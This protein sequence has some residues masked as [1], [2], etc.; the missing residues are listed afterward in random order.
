MNV[1]LFGATGTTGSKVLVELLN[2][3][4]LVK[5]V[6]RDVS[7]IQLQHPNLQPMQGNVLDPG[8]V[9]EVIKGAD[10][11]VST[12]SEG[13]SI[14][15][16]TQSKGNGNIIQA[17]QAQGIPR[18][19][20]MGAEGILNAPDGTLIREDPAYPEPY[21]PLSYEHSRVQELLQSSTLQWTQVC[22]P[23]ILPRNADGN[24]TVK[25]NVPA[26]STGKVNAGNIGAFIAREIQENKFLRTRVGIANS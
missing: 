25:P 4:Y 6:A 2:A 17:M 14:V 26:A 3:G 19:I 8:F 7:R 5:A 18:F 15:Q 16:H 1:V 24:Y 10:A 20:C 13:V 23:L 21:K 12:I 9:T 11:V 22:P